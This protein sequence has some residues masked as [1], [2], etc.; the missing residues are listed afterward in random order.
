MTS[1]LNLREA[2]LCRTLGTIS[3]NLKTKAAE[4]GI[5]TTTA[6]LTGGLVLSLPWALR[7]TNPDA[8]FT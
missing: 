7:S 5:L 3:A 4:T 8:H 1:K 6:Q 2:G